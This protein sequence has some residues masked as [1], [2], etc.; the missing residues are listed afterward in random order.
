MPFDQGMG[1]ELYGTEG[2]LHY[3]LAAD[4]IFGARRSPRPAGGREEIPIPA[5]KAR[6]WHV[7]TDFVEAI[8]SGSPIELTDFATGVAY[9]EFTEA[10]ARSAQAGVAIEL[11]LEEFVVESEG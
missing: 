3:D 5:E 7:E 6:A 9:M 2:L 1:I 11:P 8:R 4:R 10:V